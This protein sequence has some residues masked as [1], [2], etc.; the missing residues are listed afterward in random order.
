[1]SKGTSMFIFLGKNFPNPKFTVSLVDQSYD[2]Y[3]KN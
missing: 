2:M 1:M 3:F